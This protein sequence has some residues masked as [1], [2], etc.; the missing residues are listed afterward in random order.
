M[1]CVF[2]TVQEGNSICL[3]WLMWE[4]AEG[5]SFSWCQKGKLKDHQ[6]K[7]HSPGEWCLPCRKAW[8]TQAWK[9]VTA[10]WN[11]QQ[12]SCWHPEQRLAGGRRPRG[13]GPCGPSPVSLLLIGMSRF[14]CR[15]RLPPGL[16]SLL[17]TL[18]RLPPQASGCQPHRL[19]APQ[20]LPRPAFSEAPVAGRQRA[21]GDPGPGSQK[22][23]RAA[24]HDLGP[25]Q[26]TPHTRL[27]LWKPLQLGGSVSFI[28]FF[29]LL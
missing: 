29:P 17:S 18:S 7:H 13:Q 26:N 8:S 20:L 22:P 21:D 6:L 10:L 11:S 5:V 25:E 28:D 23:I 1:F 3:T 19:R 12:R 24:G 9:R 14:S 4:G 2:K 16:C 27:C 15:A